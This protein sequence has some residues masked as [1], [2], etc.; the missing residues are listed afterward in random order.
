[1]FRFGKDCLEGLKFYLLFVQIVS[2]YF[3]IK[4]KNE[5]M[6]ELS[7]KHDVMSLLESTLTCLCSFTAH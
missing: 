2:N 5:R 3:E 1:M 7:E 6:N 4:Q